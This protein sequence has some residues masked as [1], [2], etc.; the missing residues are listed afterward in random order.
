MALLE[1]RSGRRQG[2]RTLPGP[3]GPLWF[4]VAAAC[5]LARVLGFGTPG[6]VSS[7]PGVSS[8]ASVS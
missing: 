4:F 3:R 5:G 6:G 7:V 1:E 8:A 2:E